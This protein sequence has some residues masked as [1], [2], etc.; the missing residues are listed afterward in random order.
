MGYM[1]AGREC[2]ELGNLEC[3]DHLLSDRCCCIGMVTLLPI[4]LGGLL[5][6]KEHWNGMD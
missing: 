6:A 3:L 5:D 4:I 2:M 1:S